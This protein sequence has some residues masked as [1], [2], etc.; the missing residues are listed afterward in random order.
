MGFLGFWGL[1]CFFFFFWF[2]FFFFFFV[3]GFCFGFLGCLGLGFK[4]GRGFGVFAGNKG[5]CWGLGG[6]GGFFL[7][8][9]GGGALGAVG[10]L[11]ALGALIRGFRVQGYRFGAVS[12]LRVEGSGFIAPS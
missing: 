5:F 12:G 1:L 3:F 6:F 4:R 7:G 9:G 8:G 2:L 10:A 11:G